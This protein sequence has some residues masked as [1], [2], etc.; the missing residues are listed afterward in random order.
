M[1]DENDDLET[2]VLV[3]APTARDAMATRDIL[4]AVSIATVACPTVADICRE[5]IRGAG[6]VMLT[7]EAVLA[8]K[9]GQLQAML[10]GQPAWSDLPMIVLT[11]PGAESPRLLQQLESVGLM[12]LMKRP[13]HV[14]AIVSMVRAALRDRKRQ[15]V[16]RGHLLEEKRQAARLRA[17]DARWR[18]VVDSVEDY[19]IFTL[20]LEGRVSTWNPGAERV[21]GWTEAEI[22]GRE[23]DILFTQEDR[24][25]GV[26]SREQAVAVETG[27]A[28]DER[29]HVRKDGV[30]FFASGVMT[31]LRDGHLMGYT[32]VCRD[33]TAR[34]QAEQ[35]ERFLVNLTDRTRP[36]ADAE[37]AMWAVVTA[38]ADHF[39]VT[40]CA[41]TEVDEGAG[42]ITVHRDFHEGVPSLSGIHS[43]ESFGPAVIREL[44]KGETVV[45]NDTTQDKR[46]QGAEAAYAAL[47][48]RAY[49]SVP[50]VKAGRL[51]ATLNV[52]SALP[53]DWSVADAA[54]VKETAERAWQSVEAARAQSRLAESER[55]FRTLFESMDQG[56][57]V[58]EVSFFEGQP[59]DY[60]FV[61][62]NPAFERHSG[63]P[64]DLL[65]KSIRE[66]VPG[67][68]EFWFDTYGRVAVTG[69]PTR[70]VHYAAPLDRWFDVYAFRLEDPERNRLAVLFTDVSDRKRAEETL[71][72]ADRKKDDFIALLAHE[73]RNPLAPVR[74][75]L[76]VLRLSQ[77][78]AARDRAQAMMDRQLT[79]MVRLIDDLLDVSRISRNKMELRRSRIL[80]A[81]AVSSAVE[82]AR[83][84]IEAA[85]HELRIDIPSEPI[86][87]DADLTRIAQV[88]ANLLTNSAKYTERGGRIDLVARRE[89]DNAVV[90]VFDTGI[91]IPAESLPLIFD[92]FSQVDRSIERS[93]GGLGIGLA[94][95]KGLVEMHG[96]TV[97]AVS[98]GQDRG[99]VFTVKL[100]AV[101]LHA[102][103]GGK[104]PGDP[105]AGSAV[106]PG[107]RI[108][109]VDDNQDSAESMGEMLRLFGHEVAV[110]HDGIEAVEQ[111]D[112]FRP[113]MILMDIG[114]PRL[115]GY[116]ATRRIRAQP[117]GKDITIL[118]L[119]GWGQ[120]G[121]RSK[122]KEAG[123]NGHLVKP[124]SLPDLQNALADFAQAEVW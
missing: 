58:I 87:L 75:G 93:T 91:G 72:D 37:A 27:R 14:S 12:T 99:S 10:R 113:Q 57:C 11:P 3:Q 115:N 18:L 103:S 71:R 83:P 38:L 2:R 100:P 90:S 13:V 25:A 73:L 8:D 9:E 15:Y 122:S 6:V 51:V 106:G 88:F 68:E 114:M 39:G 111:A 74:N 79:H 120:E 70:F 61:E 17:A 44:R 48:C 124:V 34:R 105:N 78:W 47:G 77:D 54:L 21:F 41:Y 49:L 81:D 52:M 33:V 104:L 16:V 109:I 95:V 84:M 4:A 96:G 50:L 121:D 24:A 30:R 117:W 22:R 110:A 64:Q 46:I 62:L 42:T 56:F 36:V 66:T 59:N 85:K 89:G 7:A 101:P 31:P 86:L 53:R 26:P 118:A 40:R 98:A 65:G 32:K 60:R 116:D 69:K 67:L 29:W 123:C 80:L 19:A 112:A 55:R 94:L 5:A 119:T 1:V 20:D 43:L 92:M 35:R 97:T 102:A 76:Q 23:V 82:T 107:R 63:L 108:L 45:V 28:E